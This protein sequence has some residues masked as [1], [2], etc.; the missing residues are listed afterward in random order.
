MLQK[1]LLQNEGKSQLA[2]AVGKDAKGNL[3]L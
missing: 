1:L 2:I 3:A